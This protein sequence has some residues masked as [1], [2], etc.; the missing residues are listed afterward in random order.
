MDSLYIPKIVNE[1]VS[2]EP[3][4]M[5]NKLEYHILKKLQNKYEGKCIK[6]GYIKKDSIKILKRSAGKMVSSHFNG[7]VIF[8]I[9][10][11]VELCNPL[12]GASIECIVINSNKMGVLAEII[13]VDDSPLNILLA[14]FDHTQLLLRYMD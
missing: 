1:S 8:H 9:E 13:G 14:K 4:Y 11:L 2:I 6:E 3:R 5:N 7:N 10:Y 12:E